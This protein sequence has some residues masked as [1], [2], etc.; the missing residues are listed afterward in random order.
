MVVEALR[1]FE[2]RADGQARLEYGA[3]AAL[4][5]HIGARYPRLF[6]WTSVSRLLIAQR[7]SALGPFDSAHL[8]VS[9]EY[10]KGVMFTYLGRAGDRVPWTRTVAPELVI[11]RFERFLDDLRWVV[12]LGRMRRP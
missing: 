5:E 11:D 7:D 9:S 6:G 3:I 12:R 8:I 2:R 1:G 4:A 10:G